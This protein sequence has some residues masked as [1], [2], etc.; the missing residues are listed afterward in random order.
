MVKFNFLCEGNRNYIES[1]SIKI[2]HFMLFNLFLKLCIKILLV[3]VYPLP[4]HI[5]GD[6]DF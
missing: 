5:F 4:L 3:Y 1:N 6:L 2:G